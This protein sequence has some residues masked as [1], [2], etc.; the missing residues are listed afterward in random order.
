MT[1]P[2]L[3]AHSPYGELIGTRIIHSDPEQGTIEIE[4]EARPEFTN[5]I[6]TIAGGMVAG[7]LDS[8]TGLVA[9]SVVRVGFF[10][11][12]ASM[13]VEYHRPM[14]IGRVIGRARVTAQDERDI[15]AEGELFDD[16]GQRLASGEAR[17]RVIRRPDERG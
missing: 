6:G 4:Y 14:S 9:N 3:T 11:V 17:L 2:N 16:A 10:A 1:H 15:R 12:H 8:V 13:N 5:R 7:L